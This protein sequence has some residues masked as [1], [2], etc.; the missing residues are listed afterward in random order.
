MILIFLHFV[1]ETEIKKISQPL[2]RSFF[3][4][5]LVY[6]GTAT[7][8]FDKTEI[9]LKSGDLFFTF[10]YQSFSIDADN[11]FSFLYISFNGDDV[12]PLLDNFNIT[13][14]NCIFQNYNNLI[15]FLDGYNQANKQKQRK[16]SG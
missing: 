15:V 14:E 13:K 11:N 1:Y 10:P 4:M 7:L 6:K 9:P 12:K 3:M 2:I 5:N 16:C 8:K